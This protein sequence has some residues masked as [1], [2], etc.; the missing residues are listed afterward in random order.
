MN[1]F[2]TD[3][4][5]WRAMNFI[6][7][8]FILNLLFIIFSL[9]LFTIG[10]STTALYYALMVRTRR[11]EGYVYKNFIKSF[12]DNFKNSTIIWI[13]MLII[14][15]V[16]YTDYRI[17]LAAPGLMG[18]V[19][20]VSSVILAIFYTMV[21]TYIFPIQAKFENTIKDNLKNALLMPIA[22]LG[23]TALIFMFFIIFILLAFKS[24]VFLGLLLIIG[25]ALYGF[26]TSNIFISVFRKHLP[27][28]LADDEEA[29]GMDNYR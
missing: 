5:L 28:E 2:S 8:I 18:K 9:P 25:F 4:F 21:L 6:A 1:V 12:K 26:I 7:E 27:D 11:N 14:G 23:Y 3:G 17:G 24:H 22:H 29:Y 16:I 10:A 15:F 19:M 13:I 20:I